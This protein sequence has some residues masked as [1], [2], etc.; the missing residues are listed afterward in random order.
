M[1]IVGKKEPIIHAVTKIRKKH[2]P[3]YQNK[4]FKPPPPPKEHGYSLLVFY[5]NC[6]IKERKV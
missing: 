2:M 4:H 6:K 3:Q 5:L 1:T